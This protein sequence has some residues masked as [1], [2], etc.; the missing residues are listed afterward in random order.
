[1]I[2]AKTLLNEQ[3][4]NNIIKLDDGYQIF[5]NIRSSPPYFE[6]KK[7]NLMA[8]IHQLGIPTLFISLSAADIKWIDLLSSIKTLLTNRLCSNH[9]AYQ[10][11]T[12]DSSTVHPIASS[13]NALHHHHCSIE[14]IL[15]WWVVP[16]QQRVSKAVSSTC[17]RPQKCNLLKEPLPKSPFKAECLPPWRCLQSS[18]VHPSSTQRLRG[19]LLA[20]PP[21]LIVVLW[22]YSLS[23]GGGT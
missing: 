16:T 10:M 2:T 12:C 11:G 22:L 19:Q 5:K 9:V 23:C 14:E 18:D 13:R 8:M 6:N 1:M 15:V 3:S 17:C 7:K 4:R 21:P 20:A